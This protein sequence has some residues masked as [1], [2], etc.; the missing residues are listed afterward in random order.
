MKPKEVPEVLAIQA[1]SRMWSIRLHTALLI[2]LFSVSAVSVAETSKATSV[3]TVDEK[4]FDYFF[5]EAINLKQKEKY[6]ESYQLFT[7]C[8]MLDS[9]NSQPWFELSVFYR[10]LERNDL[11]LKALEKAYNLDRSNEWYA[12]GLANMYITVERVNDAVK[13]YTELSN[14]R[15][16]DENLLFQLASLYYQTNDLKSALNT[17]NRAEMLVG[18][19]ES[20]SFEKYKIYKQEGNTK[21]AIKEIEA[22]IGEFPYD[23][24]YLLLLGD[25]WMD[26][27]FP[28]KAYPKYMD[29]QKRDPNNPSVSL[30][31]ADYYK[32]TG[33]SLASNE[34][35]MNALT[36]P[37][38]DIET[39]LTIFSPVLIAS[40][41]TKDTVEIQKYFD[42]LLEQHPN[43]YQI[44][45]LYVKWL[46]ERGR[47]QEAKDELR[48]VLD[49]NP[50]Q[51][52][53]WKNFLE[54]NLEF[55]NQIVIR[56]ICN[57]ALQYFSEEPLFWFYLGL[58]WTSENEGKDVDKEKTKKAIDAF[59][60]GISV[61]KNEEK[62]FISRL[63]GITGD[64]Y[65]LLNDT[66]KAFEYYEKALEEF[67]GNLL[68][69]NN[70]A[71]YLA[72]LGRDLSKAERMSR[73]TIEADPKNSTYLDTFA[74]IFF[75]LEKYSLA[76][77][78]IERA[79]ANEKDPGPEIVEHYGDILW[80]CSEK[81]EAKKQWKK[82]AELNNPSETLLKKIE[83]GTYVP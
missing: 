74:W 21:K 38:T 3:A 30:S 72:V 47:K 63:Y 42:I 79:I 66:I 1:K 10:N 75:K 29:A 52:K 77:I 43:E 28:K 67:Q 50:N 11:A 15:P 51:L 55:D 40:L 25:A 31:L 13:L 12:L 83:T 76:K 78:Y 49:L 68:V 46:L 56:D 18:K 20:I 32:E 23:V 44:R 41:Q 14:A 73:K 2:L 27:G 33:D 37:G 69:L 6:A 65:L 9:T 48:N 81:E 57:E 71:Y 45:D 58:S 60:K 54:L 39:K 17:L 35:L 22:L 34:Q 80:F 4:I 7:F 61:S 5:N 24:D 82:S 26:L 59:N 36:N 64:A 8:T 19:N 70:Y 53:A 62:P 16:D